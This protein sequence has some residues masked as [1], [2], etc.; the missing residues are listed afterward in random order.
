MSLFPRPSLPELDR[1]IA[2]TLAQLQ[3]ANGEAYTELLGDLAAFRA[4]R[5]QVEKEEAK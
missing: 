1:R 3:H 5:A 2:N 4:L